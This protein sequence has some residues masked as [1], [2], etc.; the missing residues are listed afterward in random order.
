MNAR[1]KFVFTV[2]MGFIRNARYAEAAVPG[3]SRRGD[4]HDKGVARS[5]TPHFATTASFPE[6]YVDVHL[7]VAWNRR[8]RCVRLAPLYRIQHA[9]TRAVPARQ[10]MPCVSPEAALASGCLTGRASCL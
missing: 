3:V 8:T 6:L 4:R 1:G 7:F 2:A 5:L 10:L 9:A